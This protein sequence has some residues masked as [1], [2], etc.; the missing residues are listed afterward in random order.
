[1]S[2]YGAH[3]GQDT[4]VER[5]DA[6]PRRR[7]LDRVDDHP[8]LQE[9]LEARNGIAVMEPT[10]DW[11]RADGSPPDLTGDP[12]ARADLHFHELRG[13]LG[14]D[15]QQTLALLGSAR[16]RP[17][18]LDLIVETEHGRSP[19]SPH[20]PTQRFQTLTHARKGDRLLQ[21]RRRK[22][23]NRV[24]QLRQ[25]PRRS[26]GPEEEVA[27]SLASGGARTARVRTISPFGSTASKA[28]NMSSMFPYL[29]EN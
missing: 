28:T 1:M 18:R 25:Y 13:S 16:E 5:I 3:A 10:V 27:E 29:V 20:D 9:I 12:H 24:R 11:L 26:F 22:R 23:M 4:G 6:I 15:Q 2:R 21:R 8:L 7:D 19:S 14:E 17:P